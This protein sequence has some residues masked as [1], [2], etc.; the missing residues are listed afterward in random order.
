MKRNRKKGQ[1]KKYFGDALI[2]LG[3]AL[4]AFILAIN[5]YDL[6]MSE[7]AIDDFYVSKLAMT[8]SIERL[9]EDDLD[10]EIVQSENEE[11]VV[12]EENDAEENHSYD[13][14]EA[15]GVLHIS[16]INL[17]EAICEGSTNNVLSSA[18]GHMENTAFPGQE[19]NCCI[20]GHRNYVFGKYFN[21]LNEIEIGDTINIECYE[22][23]Y[24][25][26][27]N[28]IFVVEPE[29]V[30]VLDYIEG[31]NLTLITCTPIFVGSH[32]LIIRAELVE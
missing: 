4:I 17:E 31:K 2:I 3:C 8:P 22:N 19:G 15:I 1:G 30:N 20:A 10:E 24:K 21:R 7:K 25:Y 12:F 18:L 6:I 5:A 26:I 27:V 11:V 32:R 9:E 14:G 16:K 28:D 13:A 29:A 23:E